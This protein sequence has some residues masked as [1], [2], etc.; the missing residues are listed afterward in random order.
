MK[1]LITNE[2]GQAIVECIL[3]YALIF[4]LI[5]IF[6]FHISFIQIVRV[7]LQMAN[8]FMAYTAAHAKNPNT[9]RPL[10][11]KVKLMLQ[12]GP[13]VMSNKNFNNLKLVYRSGVY[14]IAR[15][16]FPT[17]FKLLTLNISVDYKYNSQIMKKIMGKDRLKLSSVPIKIIKPG[18][19]FSLKSIITGK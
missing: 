5:A 14:R 8:R 15:T 4:L 19:I 3:F 16:G 7:R 12:N 10:E 6:L 2:K 9:G 17:P 1:N 13:P 18:T 11:E